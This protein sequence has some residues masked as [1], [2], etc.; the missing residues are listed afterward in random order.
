MCAWCGKLPSITGSKCFRY[1]ADCLLKV[2]LPAGSRCGVCNIPIKFRYPGLLDLNR[3]EK[4][5]RK[6]MRDGGYP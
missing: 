5:G 4:C 2:T 6:E 3:C 1:C